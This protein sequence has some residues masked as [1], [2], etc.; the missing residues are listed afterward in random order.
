[1]MSYDYS[2]HIER[3]QASFDLGFA[4]TLSAVLGQT[5]TCLAFK[6]DLNDQVFQKLARFSGE[7][8]L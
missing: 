8:Y 6:E 1:M 3:Q 7:S 2:T 5:S 4:F